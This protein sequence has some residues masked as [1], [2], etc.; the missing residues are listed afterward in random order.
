MPARK[1]ASAIL[2]GRNA[3]Q[4]IRQLAG[5]RKTQVQLAEQYGVT[6]SAISHFS[7]RHAD[8]IEAYKADASAAL[9]ELWIT[10][11]RERLA[12]LQQ[13]VEEAQSKKQAVQLVR[14]YMAEAEGL[15]G[16]VKLKLIEDLARAAGTGT[17]WASAAQKALRNAAEELGQL[18]TATKIDVND[19][20]VS[21]EVVG[22][23][24]DRL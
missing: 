9:D 17:S 11:K 7:K 4:L 15:D 23:D 13:Q 2:E 24:M 16:A 14:E 21:I 8:A 1:V 10:D 5:G 19:N 3:R 22:V 6:Q 12:V 20:R 18:P